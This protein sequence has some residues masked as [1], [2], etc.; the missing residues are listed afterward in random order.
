MVWNHKKFEER[1][2][3]VRE[4]K[5]IAKFRR[6]YSQFYSPDS[7]RLGRTPQSNPLDW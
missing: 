4:D 6:W 3:L 5:A 7:P 2:L 1:P